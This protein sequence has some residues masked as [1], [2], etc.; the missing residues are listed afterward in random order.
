M[1][2]LGV[3]RPSTGVA[4]G[5]PELTVSGVGSPLPVG[6]VLGGGYQKN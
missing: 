1:T 6:D 2:G 3:D 4:P 5:G